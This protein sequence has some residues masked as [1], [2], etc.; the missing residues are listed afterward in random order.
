MKKLKHSKLAKESN[1][2]IIKAKENYMLYLRS[3]LKKVLKLNKG[4]LMR[5]CE[6]VSQRKE[7]CVNETLLQ[8]L[9]L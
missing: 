6:E 8:C 9:R 1:L 7:Y 2:Q 5:Q 4:A 3:G